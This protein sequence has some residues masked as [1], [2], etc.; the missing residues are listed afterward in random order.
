MCSVIERS[1]AGLDVKLVR[2]ARQLHVS[3]DVGYIFKHLVRQARPRSPG[4]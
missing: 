3:A 2:Q 4:A 1:A